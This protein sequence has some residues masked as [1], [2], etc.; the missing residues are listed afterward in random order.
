MLECEYED[1]A[2]LT[3]ATYGQ[4]ERAFSADTGMAEAIVV[5]TKKR[6][7]RKESGDAAVRQS[8]PPTAQPLRSL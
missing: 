3:I 2:V 5:A 4:T 7:G 8:P 1:L 6:D